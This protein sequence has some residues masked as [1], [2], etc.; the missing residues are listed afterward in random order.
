MTFMFFGLCLAALYAFPFLRLHKY[1]SRLYASHSTNK[2]P[3]RYRNWTRLWKYFER[4]I[5]FI[6]VW[7]CSFTYS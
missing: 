4:D 6:I 1:L 2:A 7:K 5:F 3:T